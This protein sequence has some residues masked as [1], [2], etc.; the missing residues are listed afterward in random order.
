[1]QLTFLVSRRPIVKN[2]RRW[3]LLWM[4]KPSHSRRRAPLS[5]ATEGPD[6]F[7]PLLSVNGWG[8]TRRVIF[9][10]FSS[11][12]VDV[13]TDH[14]GVS[15][16]EA[17][18][19]SSATVRANKLRSLCT[20]LS[21]PSLEKPWNKPLLC[22]REAETVTWRGFK[23]LRMLQMTRSSEEATSVQSLIW[24]L[25]LYSSLK[26]TAFAL[27]MVPR[28]RLILWWLGRAGPNVARLVNPS[29]VH[30]RPSRSET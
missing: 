18:I 16:K 21:F 20:L 17:S 10:T 9:L 30:R 14:C 24:V 29:L 26:S 11:M 3:T 5:M 27:S 6:I 23:S 19:D 25:I 13:F 1:M 8:S 22:Q 12:M 2:R 15:R 7:L 28:M 4:E